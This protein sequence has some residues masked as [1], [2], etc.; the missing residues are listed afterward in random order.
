MKKIVLKT[1]MSIIAM[2]CF[3]SLAIR[4]AP[5]EA[6]A[7]AKVKKVSAVA[8]SGKTAYVA[9]GKRLNWQRP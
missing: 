8:P 2:A 9:K 3:I 5:K 4:K 6:E 1:L 7:K